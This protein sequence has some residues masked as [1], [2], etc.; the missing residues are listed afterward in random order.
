MENKNTNPIK[1]ARE[2]GFSIINSTEY[3]TLKKLEEEIINSEISLNLLKS[4]E[5]IQSSNDNSTSI[6]NLVLDSPKTQ[7]IQ[8]EINDSTIIK[9]YLEGKKSYEKLLKNVFNIIEYMTGEIR[10]TSS[11]GNGCCGQCHNGCAGCEK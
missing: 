4:I 2:L 6:E 3:I 7:E 9:Q 5:A 11:S 10:A 1:L 8:S